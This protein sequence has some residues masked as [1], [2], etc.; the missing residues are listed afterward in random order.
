MADTKKDVQMTSTL[1]EVNATEFCV[2]KRDREGSGV[3]FF[4]TADEAFIVCFADLSSSRYFASNTSQFRV[5]SFLK[6]A[7]YILAI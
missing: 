6:L 7:I 2:L 3:I 5:L 1:A 4:R